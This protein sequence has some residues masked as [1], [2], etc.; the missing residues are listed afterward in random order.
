MDSEKGVKIDVVGQE[1]GGS[2][3]TTAGG[4]TTAK[5]TENAKILNPD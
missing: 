4:K 1:G 3:K 2:S 5:Q